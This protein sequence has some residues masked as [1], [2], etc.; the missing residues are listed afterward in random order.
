MGSGP[1]QKEAPYLVTNS[2]ETPRVLVNDIFSCPGGNGLRH[3][4]P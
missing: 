4:V 3:S 2:L 1:H